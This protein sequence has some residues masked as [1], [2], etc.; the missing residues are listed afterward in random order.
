MF[1]SVGWN[2]RQSGL[3]GVGPRL[4]QTHSE[5]SL[6]M[7]AFAW[8]VSG[9]WGKLIGISPRSMSA[10]SER[11]VPL[12]FSEMYTNCLVVL[13]LNVIFRGRVPRIWTFDSAIP[14]MECLVGAKTVSGHPRVA[15]KSR[16]AVQ[17]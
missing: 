6:V 5:D 12:T 11:K 16:P 7:Q 3:S 17:V 4:G 14:L 1:S 10:L 13:L 9:G 15:I 8:H 2:G